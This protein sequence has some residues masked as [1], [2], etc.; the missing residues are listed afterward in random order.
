[1]L[2]YFV[3]TKPREELE[4]VHS[5]EPLQDVLY[6]NMEVCVR[7]EGGWGHAWGPVWAL[8]GA[9]FNCHESS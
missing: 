1:M 8:Y 6:S 7:E 9:D 5:E 3:P 2:M 4:A